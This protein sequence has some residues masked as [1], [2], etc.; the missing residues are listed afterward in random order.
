MKIR[1]P[2]YQTLTDKVLRR[3][4]VYDLLIV[5][6]AF[7]GGLASALRSWFSSKEPWDKADWAAVLYLIG[8]IVIVLLASA[9]FYV[10]WNKAEH[11]ETAHDLEGC[12]HAI[13][14]VLLGSYEGDDDAGLRLTIH[15]PIE[16]GNK[17][18]Q[19]IEYVGDGRAKKKTAGR[20]FA[21]QSGVIGVALRTKLLSEGSW[22]GQDYNELVNE[23]VNE[24]H[25]TEADAKA[26]NRDSRAWL[27][28]PLVHE[29]DGV[30]VV[31]AVIYADSTVPGFFDED[32]IQTIIFASE[33][34]ARFVQR[35]YS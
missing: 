7:F 8:G 9:K 32:R 21:A 22:N 17:L 24:W 2:G 5:F 19:I 11:D 6:A 29:E 31:V 15:R 4:I 16:D 30:R 12:L 26:L 18:E 13:H 3:K 27:A 10:E 20:K 33:G 14:S 28:N 25:Y 1:L 23:L 35:R 34:V